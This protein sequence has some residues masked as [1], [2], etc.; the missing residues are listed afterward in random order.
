M[1]ADNVLDTREDAESLGA[2]DVTVRR[3]AFGRQKDSFETS[4]DFT[5]IDR[6]VDAVFIRAPQIEEVGADVQVLAQVD[7]AVV[8]AR[9][10]HVLVTSFHPELTEDHQVHEYFV[11]MVREASTRV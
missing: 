8:A 9:Q 2:I 10:D 6:P 3:N 5:G 4:L 7:S 1:L 11:Q